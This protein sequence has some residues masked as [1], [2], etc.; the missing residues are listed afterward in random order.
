MK[1]IDLW[2][3]EVE[4]KKIKEKPK[5]PTIKS[6]FRKQHGVVEG[7]FCKECKHFIQY[8]YRN[9]RYFKCEMLGLSN[10]KATD[11][12]KSDKACRLYEKEE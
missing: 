6:K 11:I 8:D 2:G 10:S 1:Q 7:K 12:R 9:R 4:V 3:N 5:R